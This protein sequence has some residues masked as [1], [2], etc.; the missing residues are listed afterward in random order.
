MSEEAPVEFDV[1]R[2][3]GAVTRAVTNRER[4]G[5]PARAVVASRDYDTTPDD[6]W[7]A[8]TNPERIPRWFLPVTGDL[9]LGGRYQLQGN[10]SGEITR[11]EPPRHL[12]LTWEFAGDVSWVTVELT[13]ANGRTH[14][15]LEHIAYV[16][17]ARWNQYGP[18][19]VGVGWDMT[20]MGLGRY[21]AGGAAVDPK[22]AM[23]WLG[24]A[25]GK[26]FVRASSEDWCRAAIAS[27]AD[28]A[29]AKA[30]AQRTLAAYTG[31]P[32]PAKD[33]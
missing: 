29:V 13:E 14:L 21:L 3:I 4:D 1:I 15:E 27:G 6:V 32:A 33:G 2:T 5:R 16:D 12:A 7:D 17:D 11:C 22:E 19:A 10:A 18:G 30:S 26:A 23:A 20:L 25:D 31:T 8:I 9:R 24:S 28:E